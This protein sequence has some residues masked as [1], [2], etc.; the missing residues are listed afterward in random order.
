MPLGHGPLSLSK[1]LYNSLSERMNACMYVLSVFAAMFL[2]LGFLRGSS[3][4][5]VN[6]IPLADDAF[7][8]MEI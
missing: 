6:G 4:I 1:K 5:D 3:G 7:A 2:P 8:C